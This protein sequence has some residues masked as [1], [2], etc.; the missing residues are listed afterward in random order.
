MRS[1]MSSLSSPPPPPASSCAASACKG[2]RALPSESNTMR[3]PARS[4]LLLLLLL[5]PP[6]RLAA[7]RGGGDRLKFR[8]RAQTL[9]P[10]RPLQH[11]RQVMVA[12]L[13]LHEGAA[14]FLFVV[15]VVV[16]V[17]VVVVVVVVAVVILYSAQ[18]GACCIQGRCVVLSDD[19]VCG[20]VGSLHLQLPLLSRLRGGALLLPPAAAAAGEADARR[21]GQPKRGGEGAHVELLVPGRRNP[22]AANPQSSRQRQSVAACEDGGALGTLT[23]KTSLLDC[24]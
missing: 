14:V 21:V 10:R 12:P 18:L 3:L 19:V 11:V 4:L 22:T 5:L 17:V 24:R 13:Q 16:I 6:L 9:G 8:L 1:A 7:C 20:I 15:A 2:A 23:S